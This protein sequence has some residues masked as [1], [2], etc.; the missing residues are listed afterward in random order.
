MTSEGMITLVAF[1]M[2]SSGVLLVFSLVSGRSSRLNTRLDDLMG[3]GDS[4]EVPDSMASF[5][6]T[7]LPRMGTALVPT[8]EEE[9]TL[10]KSRLIH[11]GLYGRQA[12]PIFLGAK[13]LLMIAPALI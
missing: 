3:R 9:R 13:L 4:V 12:M 6:R 10:L 8:D 11:A 2:A 7:A 5:A 1:L